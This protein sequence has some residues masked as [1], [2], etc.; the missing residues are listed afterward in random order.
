MEFTKDSKITT[1]SEYSGSRK[2]WFSAAIDG[3]GLVGDKGGVSLFSSRRE[4][5]A[6]AQRR[7]DQIL[8]E[9]EPPNE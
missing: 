7:L 5:R 4:A 2:P 6:E 8:R 3:V 1:H 9:Q